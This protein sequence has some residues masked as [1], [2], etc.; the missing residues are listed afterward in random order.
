M[1]QY[2]DEPYLSG[3]LAGVVLGVAAFWIV[4]VANMLW[5]S[6]LR[7]YAEAVPFQL[8]EAGFGASFSGEGEVS[9]RPVRVKLIGGLRGPRAR[10]WIGDARHLV[11]LSDEE[12]GAWLGKL[13]LS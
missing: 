9:G 11:D 3:V 12:P 5:R 8:R 10:V 7:P 13:G 4:V 1:S 2:V 6:A